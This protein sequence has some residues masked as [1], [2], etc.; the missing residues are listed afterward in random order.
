VCV[1]D[2]AQ[3]SRSKPCLVGICD[4]MVWEEVIVEHVDI[5][6]WERAERN[7]YIHNTGDVL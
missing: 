1:G 7:A 5:D 4:I 2:A 3:R 6:K